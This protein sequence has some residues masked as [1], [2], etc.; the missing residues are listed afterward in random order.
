MPGE[1][2]MNDKVLAHVSPASAIG[3]FL[4]ATYYEG[5][6]HTTLRFLLE[7]QLLVVSMKTSALS[8]GTAGS[9][10]DVTQVL[11]AVLILVTSFLRLTR[12]AY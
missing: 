10:K 3:L 12:A 5:S 8:L 1:A 6:D 7:S 11:H 2:L 9:F 4:F